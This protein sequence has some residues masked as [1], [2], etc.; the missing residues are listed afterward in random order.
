M[1]APCST[2]FLKVLRSG[3]VLNIFIPHQESDLG[4]TLLRGLR[5]SLTGRTHLGL[6]QTT[7]P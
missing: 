7:F 3:F 6:S 2:Y 5:T 4:I 1:H